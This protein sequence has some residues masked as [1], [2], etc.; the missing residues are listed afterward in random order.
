MT[1]AGSTRTT[2]CGFATAFFGSLEDIYSRQ[3]AEERTKRTSVSAWRLQKCGI[4][5][6]RKPLRPI[7][8]AC[9]AAINPAAYVEQLTLNRIPSNTVLTREREAWLAVAFETI[10]SM[11]CSLDGDA[12]GNRYQINFVVFAHGFSIRRLVDG[13]TTV[14]SSTL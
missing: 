5:P 7:A 6:Q 8:V 3:Q 1:A 12:H 14:R 2:S 4:P 11:P 13:A 10:C 9:L